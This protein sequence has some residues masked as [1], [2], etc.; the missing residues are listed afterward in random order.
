MLKSFKGKTLINSKFFYLTFWKYKEAINTKQWYCLKYIA[1]TEAFLPPSQLNQCLCP[2]THKVATKFLFKQTDT[3]FYFSQ[4]LYMPYRLYMPYMHSC[5]CAFKNK[6][7][8]Q[9]CYINH[10]V[11]IKETRRIGFQGSYTWVA[12]YIMHHKRS[13]KC[14]YSS[15]KQKKQL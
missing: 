14:Q 3:E 4:V 10:F 8:R 1:C 7:C 12:S 13:L 15:Y 5:N 6:F 9:Y 11:K 2:S